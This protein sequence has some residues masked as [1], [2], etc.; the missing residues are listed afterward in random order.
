MKRPTKK[1]SACAAAVGAS[2]DT[3]N[4]D[5]GITGERV[6]SPEASA[7]ITGADGA[8]LFTQT[9]ARSGGASVTFHAE[10]PEEFGV[11]IDLEVTAELS[12][13]DEFVVTITRTARSQFPTTRHV[14]TFT[15]PS[16]GREPEA[17]AELLVAAL[18]A[19]PRLRAAATAVGV[20]V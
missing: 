10:L 8:P 20:G 9:P 17:H 14:S 7:T 2:Q 16:D 18:R 6:R 3:V 1:H 12:P 5:L 15:I 19:L 11:R 13:R 4:R